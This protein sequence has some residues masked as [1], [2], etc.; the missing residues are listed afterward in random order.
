M[1]RFWSAALVSAGIAGLGGCASTQTVPI[2]CTPEEVSFYVDGRLLEESPDE[3]VLRT[4]EPH[5]IYVK[6]PGYE[7]QLVV[8]DSSPD[9]EGELQ[10][11]PASLC[12]EP[13]PIGMGRDLRIEVE[14]GADAEVSAGDP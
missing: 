7:P 3:L 5:K 8:L 10:L 9:A 1:I 11:S 2:E 14:P 4:D 13:V 12:I 6:G